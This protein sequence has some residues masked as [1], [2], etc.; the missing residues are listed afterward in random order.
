MCITIAIPSTHP[1]VVQKFSEAL[2]SMSVVATWQPLEND[3]PNP[4]MG[5]A[6]NSQ[7][8]TSSKP[9]KHSRKP[10]VVHFE[11]DL[12]ISCTPNLKD[13]W[14]QHYIIKATNHKFYSQGDDYSFEGPCRWSKQYFRA[15]EL[16]GKGMWYMLVFQKFPWYL[17]NNHG[18]KAKRWRSAC[19]KTE[20][21]Q[22][23]VFHFLKCPIVSSALLVFL[24]TIGIWV[25]VNTVSRTCNEKVIQYAAKL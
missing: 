11:E 7:T 13:A 20:C 23:W 17:E 25:E 12:A 22:E 1:T 8:I 16:G 2:K 3:D 4:A 10:F 5:M 9:G 21:L 19:Q 24:D 15:W 14:K 6:R 18:N